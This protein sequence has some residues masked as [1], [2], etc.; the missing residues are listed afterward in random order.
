[1]AVV[2]LH[3]ESENFVVVEIFFSLRKEF[4]YSVL[5]CSIAY[6]TSSVLFSDSFLFFSF[7]LSYFPFCHVRN[8]LI[9]NNFTSTSI[10]K[11]A[12]YW[13]SI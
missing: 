1:M 12:I 9:T 2:F 4:I 5:Y 7:H 11:L 6:H 13:I 8:S 3:T 10:Y